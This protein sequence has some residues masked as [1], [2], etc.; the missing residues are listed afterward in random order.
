MNTNLTNCARNLSDSREGYLSPLLEV[1]L[2]EVERGFLL[3]IGEEDTP[4]SF[5]EEEGTVKDESDNW[6]Y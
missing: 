3:S 2:C 1:Y 5:S 4:P 6:G